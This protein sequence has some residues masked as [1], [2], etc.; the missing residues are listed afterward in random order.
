MTQPLNWS[1]KVIAPCGCAANR[2]E[3][4]IGNPPVTVDIHI[5]RD[6]RERGL[7]AEMKQ[8]LNNKLDSMP[9]IEL[10]EMA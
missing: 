6:H 4:I 5:C 8:S 7:S 9:L 3:W 10:G 2:R 1:T